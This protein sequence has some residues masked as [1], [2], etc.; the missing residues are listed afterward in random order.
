MNA[1]AIA[2]ALGVHP[3]TIYADLRAFDQGG[4]SALVHPPLRGAPPRL[5]PDQV[6][7]IVRLAQQDPPELGLPYGR[8]SLS[9]LRV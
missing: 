7:L 1:H 3:N 5:H 4:L 2:A 9:T 8:W 6:E